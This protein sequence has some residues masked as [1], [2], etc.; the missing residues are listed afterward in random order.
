M[1]AARAG[2]GAKEAAEERLKRAVATTAYTLTADIPGLLPT[3]HLAQITDVI[4]NA[5]PVVSVCRQIG[6]N[7][8]QVTYP[9]ITQ[10]PIVGE[11]TAEKTDLPAQK[12]MVGMNTEAAH[13]YGGA[14]NLSWQDIAWSNPDALSLWFDL[15]AEAWARQTEAVACAEILSDP[16]IP[17]A[18]ATDDLAGWMT[19]LATAAGMIYEQSGRRADTLALDIQSGFHL[20]GLVGTEAPVF[21]AAGSGNLAAGT[22]NV[23]GLRLVISDGF[24]ADTGAVFDSSAVLCAETPGAPVELRAVEPSIAGFEVGVIG[25]FLAA[26]MEPLAVVR[27]NP[28]GGVNPLARERRG[29]GRPRKTEE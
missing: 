27:V 3:Q 17:V 22:G 13:V 16:D 28:P 10:R 15:A 14:G 8:G 21:I 23:A 25:A 5:R 12:M 9:K 18:V 1:I 11:Q 20:M 2:A 29:P 24:P 26:T 19:A 4:N 6:L 7:A